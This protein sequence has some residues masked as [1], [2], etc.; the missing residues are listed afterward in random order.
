[1]VEMVDEMRMEVG[2]EQH[3]W[4]FSNVHFFRNDSEP[5][6]GVSRAEGSLPALI[7]R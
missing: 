4:A 2:L 5:K 1:M 3:R 6:N 7:F